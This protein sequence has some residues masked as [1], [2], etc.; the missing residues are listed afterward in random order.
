MDRRLASGKVAIGYSLGWRRSVGGIFAEDYARLHTKLAW[1]I[2][3]IGP[4][5]A[6]VRQAIRADVAAGPC[7]R[8]CG[9]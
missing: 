8:R 1:Q 2:A 6:A 5:S 3:W 9:S 4:P 7:G